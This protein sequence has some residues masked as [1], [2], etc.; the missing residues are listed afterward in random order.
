MI[1]CA[2]RRN[3]FLLRNP[4]DFRRPYLATADRAVR[5]AV[6]RILGASQAV[7]SSIN[8]IVL[9]ASFTLPR[10]L[11]G[12]MYRPSSSTLN[13]LIMLHSRDPRQLDY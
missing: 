11:G 2:I 1:A 3:E 4:H 6:F 9:S 10:S 13:M 7:P 5:Y 12:L 8:L